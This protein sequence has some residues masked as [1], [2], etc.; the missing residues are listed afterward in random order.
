MISKV[1]RPL[2]LFV[3]LIG[4]G[5]VALGEESVPAAVEVKINFEDHIKPIFRQHCNSC[6]NQTE[7]KGGLA[8]DTLAGVMAGGGSGEIVFDGDAQGSRLWQLIAHED[9]PVMPPGQD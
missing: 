9:T 4:F 2:W 5:P 8:L 1:L 6:H 3:F 7:A